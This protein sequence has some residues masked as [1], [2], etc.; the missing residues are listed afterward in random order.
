MLDVA[1]EDVS[2]KFVF[3]VS[4]AAFGGQTRESGVVLLKGFWRALSAREEL[5]PLDSNVAFDQ[6]GLVE[7]IPEFVELQFRQL[8]MGEPLDQLSAAFE[9]QHNVQCGDSFVV[10]VFNGETADFSVFPGFVSSVVLGLGCCRCGGVAGE[11]LE[12]SLASFPRWCGFE[13]RIFSG[14]WG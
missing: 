2:D 14:W 10:G 7:V 13:N 6:K 11:A 3:Q 12:F 8:D 1:N 5:D 9:S 4:E